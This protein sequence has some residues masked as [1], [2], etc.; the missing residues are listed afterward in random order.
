MI[1]NIFILIK[2]IIK[3]DLSGNQ[4][5]DDG[6]QRLLDSTEKNKTITNLNLSNNK[7][8]YCEAVS[9]VVRI[10]NDNVFER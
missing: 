1:H 2:T 8:P 10:R 3:L 7:S 6:A 4:I 5:E 9:K